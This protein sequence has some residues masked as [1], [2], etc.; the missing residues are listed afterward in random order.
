M[1][2]D[3]MQQILTN[4]DIHVLSLRRDHDC[5]SRPALCDS[6]TGVINFYEIAMERLNDATVLGF[7]PYGRLQ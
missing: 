4:A 1:S 3:Q 7:I 2:G 5:F 6:A